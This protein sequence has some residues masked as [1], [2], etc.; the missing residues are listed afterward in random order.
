LAP[1]VDGEA[2]SAQEAFL[3][4]ALAS[5]GVTFAIASHKGRN[6]MLWGLLG[7]LF[8]LIAILVCAVLP[9]RKSAY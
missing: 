2:M 5:G 3:I 7:F 6:P 4:G 8:G 9:G 1:A